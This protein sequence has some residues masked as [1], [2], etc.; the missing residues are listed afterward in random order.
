MSLNF[1]SSASGTFGLPS[2]KRSYGFLTVYLINCSRVM[3]NTCP[4]AGAETIIPA[5]TTVTGNCN[6]LAR[7]QKLE[8]R[9]DVFVIV[10]FL[11]SKQA[12][13]YRFRHH[14]PIRSRGGAGG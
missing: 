10:V 7:K 13:L 3:V 6:H 9:M 14:V 2:G 4:Q 12:R 8:L 5:S 11:D 1:S